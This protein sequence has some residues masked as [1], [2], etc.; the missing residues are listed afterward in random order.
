MDEDTSHIV[1]TIIG[2]S[3]PL[4][5]DS[6]SVVTFSSGE[7][8][9]SILCG[10]TITGGT[11]SINQNAFRTGGGINLVDCGAKI[12]NNWIIN[13]AI[14]GG[15]FCGGAGICQ[16][17]P[18]ISDWAIIEYNTIKNNRIFG[19][20]IGVGGGMVVSGNRRITNNVIEYN[21]IQSQS[22]AAVGGGINCANDNVFLT[23][24]RKISH[25]II[26]HNKAL[27]PNSNQYDGG[28]GGGI[29]ISGRSAEISYNTITHNEIQGSASTR[30]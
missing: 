13:N 17:P 25:N 3:Q 4:Q 21:T 2:G 9:T 23:L 10:F 30:S 15:S 24:T 12:I 29:F 28:M 11:G 16:S 22:D 5:S 26:R 18:G 8:T 27:E 1:N 20:D 19:T 6:G 14:S 7:D